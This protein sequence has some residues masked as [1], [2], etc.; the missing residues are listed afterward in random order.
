MST[1]NRWRSDDLPRNH[2]R[3]RRR[4][5]RANQAR[6]SLRQ[7]DRDDAPLRRVLQLV[8]HQA[9]SRMRE[10]RG[11]PDR[12]RLR[13]PGGRS[14]TAYRVVWETEIDDAH[15]PQDAAEKALAILR[16]PK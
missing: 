15:S 12:E 9:L 4:T 2:R 1:S 16:D 5:G 11:D 7:G 6:Y 10:L 8:D 3:Q 14:V 13:N